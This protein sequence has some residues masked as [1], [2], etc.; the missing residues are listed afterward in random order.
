MDKIFNTYV[1]T[2]S[3]LKVKSTFEY[4]VKV[5]PSDYTTQAIDNTS[6]SSSNLSFAWTPPSENTIISRKMAVQCKL[7]FTGTISGNPDIL[8]TND[9]YVL[10]LAENFCLQSFPL[11]RCCNN[12][13][14]NINNTQ[15]DCA[16]SD[17][18]SS[19]MQLEKQDVLSTFQTGTPVMN[20][21][22]RYYV[23]AAGSSLSPFGG[24]D[25]SRNCDLIPRSAY[26]IAIKVVTSAG[27]DA[28][29]NSF[30][31]KNDDNSWSF[32]M[33][34]DVIEPVLLPPLTNSAY[35]EIADGLIGVNRLNVKY[36]LS[37]SLA[38]RAFSY[39]LNLADGTPTG[40]MGVTL[41][42]IDNSAKLLVNYLNTGPELL[43]PTRAVYNFYQINNYSKTQ[44]ITF[45]ANVAKQIQFSNLQIGEIP[46]K[47]VIFCRKSLSSC[48]P[49]DPD[50]FFPI[51]NISVSFANRVSLLSQL[52]PQDLYLLC[53]R[54][55]LQNV[56][57]LQFLGEAQRYSSLQTGVNNA[58][59]TVY[60]G[61]SILIIDPVKDLSMTN[62]YITNGS[63]TQANLSFA[64]SVISDVVQTVDVEIV[65]L[66]F[67]SRMLTCNSGSSEVVQVALNQQMVAETLKAN[68]QGTDIPS[69]VLLG[70]A[71][72]DQV[73]NR[74][75]GGSRSGGASRSGGK[76]KLDM[77]LM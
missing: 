4:P 6:A 47:L 57:Y 10:K 73:V 7:L 67:N 70:G 44:S 58:K 14:V 32:T 52:S 74:G 38:N 20:D 8:I 64:L 75:I 50:V 42:N 13:S 22:Y 34:V 17:Y 16:L 31:K 49:K 19:M 36:S 18:I 5:G 11:S 56:D 77:L 1:S 55:G 37:S 51:T 40:T 35:G 3:R 62:A 45:A 27:T 46:D 48:T 63:T 68:V 43:I 66:L 76:S 39:F 21:R 25:K 33:E 12:L 69:A 24:Y 23:D 71:N 30:I 60:L 61:G 59:N 41:T 29:A 28:V 26:P 2:D 15:I 54:N 53:K 72:M 65:C 9:L